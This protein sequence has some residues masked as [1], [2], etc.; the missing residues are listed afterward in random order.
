MS[1]S[2]KDWLP[3]VAQ[4]IEA[5]AQ[6]PAVVALNHSL[7]LFSFIETLH[8]LSMAVLGGAVL[9]LN[10]RLLGA[11]L[12][13]T[14]PQAVERAAR[15]WL[16]AGIVGTIATGI[17][18]MLAT[19]VS[20]LP[21]TAFAVKMA[22]LLTAIVLSLVVSSQARRGGALDALALSAAVLAAGLWLAA[23]ALFATTAN[24]GSGSL[25]VASTGFFLFA[26]LLPARRRLYLG[27]AATI[28]VLGLGGS[29]FL[30]ATE[31]GDALVV[32]IS[33]GTL[34][35]AAIWALAVG[36]WQRAAGESAAEIRAPQSTA[37]Q[38]A[39]FASILSW[40]TVAAAGRWI[41]FS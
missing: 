15:P 21:S 12:P 30:P 1:A 20:S 38:L 39:A 25:L 23:L 22:A 36:W 4:A 19:T 16:I 7:W 5:V 2:I 28:L 10:L 9:V 3:G 32:Q 35:V 40:V 26:A 6:T 41:G 34:V 18:M 24:L 14:S 13:D 11:A 27:G 29:F 31:Q 17:V 33:I 37:L 8:L